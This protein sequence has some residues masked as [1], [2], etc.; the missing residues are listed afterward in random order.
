MTRIHYKS[1]PYIDYIDYRPNRPG[2]EASPYTA[3]KH[4]ITTKIVYRNV[5]GGTTNIHCTVN[6]K[7][8]PEKTGPG[9]ENF[10]HPEHFGPL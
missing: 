9:T 8:D 1:S 10:M 2:F 6:W 4:F 3:L 7:N 5:Q